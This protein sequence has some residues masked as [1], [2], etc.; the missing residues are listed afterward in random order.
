MVKCQ[1]RKWDLMVM[2]I[3][4]Q[5]PITFYFSATLDYYVC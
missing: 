3:T 4:I 5:L 1:K 2:L